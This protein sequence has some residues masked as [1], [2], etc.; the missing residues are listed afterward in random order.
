MPSHV[1]RIMSD[2]DLRGIYRYLRHLGPAGQIAPAYLPPG[3]VPQGPVV[4][5]P[6]PP[7][8]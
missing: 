8:L 5:F 4:L 7:T 2:D 1:L 6:S 3:T